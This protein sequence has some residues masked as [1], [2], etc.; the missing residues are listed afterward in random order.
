M[1]GKG[2]H[3]VLSSIGVTHLHHANTIT[4][5][6]TFLEQGGL[7]SRWFVEDHNL[8]Q[9]RQSSDADDKAYNIWDRI[10]VDQVDI[11]FRARRIK[12]PNEYG[13]VL[14]IF[15]LDFLLKLPEGSDVLVT[16]CNPIYWRDTSDNER[17]FQ[18][19]EELAADI[20]FGDFGQM[21]VIR[22]PLRKVDFPKDGVKIVLD[23]PQRNITSGA[24]AYT[25]AENKLIKAAAT[26]KVKSFIGKRKCGPSCI[27]VEKYA[28]YSQKD[29][30]F[31]F[32]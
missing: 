14:F 24:N 17:W 20:R 5:S 8:A 31:S 3:R 6:C 26:G 7:L 13:P 18:D 10:F 23:D 1:Q 25:N 21:I 27:C 15:D 9:T 28:K 16:K 4:T 12:G 22:T 2:V 32:T 30:D 19:S 11:H 29:I